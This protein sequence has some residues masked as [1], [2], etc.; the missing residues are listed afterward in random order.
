MASLVKKD[1]CR[2]YEIN[3]EM[4]MLIYQGAIWT[5]GGEY[6]VDKC[7]CCYSTGVTVWH[8]GRNYIRYTLGIGS[9]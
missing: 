7:L 3:E 8:S 4:D 1:Y 6:D 5:C 9:I 2:R